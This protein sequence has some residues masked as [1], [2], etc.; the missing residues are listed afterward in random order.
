MVKKKLT[1]RITVS[2]DEDTFKSV[3]SM[4]TGSSVSV[5]W[6]VRYAVDHLLKSESGAQLLLPFNKE[7]N[8]RSMGER[9]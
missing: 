9:T 2:L 7:R 8:I 4:A 6:V 3:L 5:G 1:H